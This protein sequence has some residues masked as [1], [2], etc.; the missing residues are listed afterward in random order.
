MLKQTN[1]LNPSVRGLRITPDVAYALLLHN[2]PYAWIILM[3]KQ[4]K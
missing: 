4:T 1:C 2:I 3:L